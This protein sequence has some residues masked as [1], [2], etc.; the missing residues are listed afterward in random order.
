MAIIFA[1]RTVNV[2]I[3]RSDMEK[4]EGTCMGRYEKEMGIKGYDI[5]YGIFSD[6]GAAHYDRGRIF[7]NK[8]GMLDE[9]TNNQMS[10]MIVTIFNPMLVLAS[11]ADSVGQISLDA[12]KLAGGIAVG[13]FLVFILAGM[14]LS[15]FLKR[16]KTA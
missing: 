15:P 5:F 7:C 13:M 11:A 14:V 10:N 8:K 16:R 6:A 2:M 3:D 4:G 12:M 9:H 1:K